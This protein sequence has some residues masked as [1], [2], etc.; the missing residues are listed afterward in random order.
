[1]DY[2]ITVHCKA[3]FFLKWLKYPNTHRT[4]EDFFITYGQNIAEILL[5]SFALKLI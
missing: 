2:F 3:N 4:P 5:S 1:M